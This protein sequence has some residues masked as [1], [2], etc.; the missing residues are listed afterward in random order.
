MPVAPFM[1]VEPCAVLC[2]NL[3]PH[4]QVDGSPAKRTTWPVQLYCR[5]RPWFQVCV[6]GLT[7]APGLYMYV[8][9]GVRAR[10]WFQVCGG[11]GEGVTLVPGV[12]VCGGGGVTLVPGMGGWGGC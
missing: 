2:L 12:C 1:P 3:P 5:A 4:T 8:C 9:G 10:P 11:G 6:W 7:L